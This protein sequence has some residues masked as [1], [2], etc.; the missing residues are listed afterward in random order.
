MKKNILTT[1]VVIFLFVAP[2][3]QIKGNVFSSVKLFEKYN[4]EISGLR[5]VLSKLSFYTPDMGRPDIHLNDGRKVSID[6]TFDEDLQKFSNKILRRNGSDFVSIVVIDNN[7]GKILT[8]AEKDRHNSL[9]GKSITFDSSHPAASII[10]VITTANLLKLPGIDLDSSFSYF[11]R[12]TTLYKH[13]L[14]D[15]PN[16]SWKRW[17][18]LRKAFATSNNPI[19]GV[20]AIRQSNAMGLYK[21][22]ESFG[23]NEKVLPFPS[24]EPSNFG[25]PVDQYH[26][27]QLASGLNKETTLSPIH[28]ALIASI[29]A[30]EGQRI[31]PSL[32][33]SITI[34]KKKFSPMNGASE[35]VLH[36]DLAKEIHNVMEYTVKYGTPRRSFFSK[37]KSVLR[38]LIIGGKTGTMSGG[39]PFGQ[40]DWFIAFAKRANMAQDDKGISICVMTI[41]RKRWYVKSSV[42]A[43]KVIEYYFRN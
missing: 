29:I 19:F 14:V 41:N 8:V 25:M 7:T 26:L 27:A 4:N 9:K 15:R 6:F 36:Y 12:S 23:F 17:R 10:K 5:G 28:G 33:K 39:K 11:G 18:T 13:Q 22:A 32:I 43:R 34:D 2:N 35:E 20:A 42:V 40:R 37:K 21:T 24:L 38:D 1:F 31:T 30:N 16:K 3:L